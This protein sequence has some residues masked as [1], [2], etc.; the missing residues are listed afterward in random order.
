M[1]N[2]IVLHLH[3]NEHRRTH[4]SERH[5]RT[6]HA[7]T[8]ETSDLQAASSYSDLEPLVFESTELIHRGRSRVFR[9]VLSGAGYFDVPVVCKLRLFTENAYQRLQREA[10][11]YQTKLRD[12]Q[13][14]YIPL[15]YGLYTGNISFNQCAVCLIL[16][17]CGSSLW[18]LDR[19][20]NL[21]MEWRYASWP[22]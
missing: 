12:M 10:E 4:T 6:P 9:G 8:L 7:F 18:C 20:V 5:Q 3:L 11:V 1:T 21:N 19:G 16:E 14:Y 17:D 13:G 15:F 2:P 22:T